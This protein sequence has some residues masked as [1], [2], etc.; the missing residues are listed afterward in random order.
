MCGSTEKPSISQKT[1]FEDYSCELD[2]QAGVVTR[3]FTVRTGKGKAR[4]TVRRFL[5]ASQKELMAVSVAITPDHEAEIE[6]VPYLDGHV[7]N[8][9]TAIPEKRSGCFWKR[10][11][12]KTRLGF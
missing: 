7:E 3:R 6:C 11:K 5:S 9:S 10:K 1:P 12:P 8:I 2:M 4:V